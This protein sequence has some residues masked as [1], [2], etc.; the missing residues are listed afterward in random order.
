MGYIGSEMLNTLKGFG[1][2]II[3]IPG[4]IWHNLNRPKFWFFI[5]FIVFLARFVFFRTWTHWSDRLILVALTIIILWK[6]YEEGT[7]KAKWREEE[8][9]RIFEMM[10]KERS[11]LEVQNEK[12]D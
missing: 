5:I 9:A 3:S 4:V 10:K 1:E 8:K 2:E 12:K 7:W 6:E 11:K